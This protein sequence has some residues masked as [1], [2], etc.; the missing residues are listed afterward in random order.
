[1]I[2]KFLVII[3]IIFS[4]CSAYSQPNSAGIGFSQFHSAQIDS[5]MQVLFERGQFNGSILVSETDSII[6]QNGFGLADV[7][8]NIPFTVSTPC[9]LAS[10]TKQ[11]T[12]MAVMILADQKKLAY[13]DR[14][15]MYFPE[16]PAYADK[17]TIRR[18]LNHTSGIV[19]YVSLGLERPGLTNKDVLSALVKQDTLQFTPG[20]K[21]QYSNSGYI[22]LALIIEKVSGMPYSTFLKKNIFAPVDMK[23]TLVF[24]ESKPVIENKAI[25]Y[26]R[27]GDEDDYNLLTQG[28]G[29][30]YAT[31]ED[32]YKWD[33]ALYTEKLVK[34]ATLDEAF[35]PGKLNDGS[36]T[37]YGFG[38]G[39]GKSGDD[40][41]ASHAGRYGG[42]NTYIKRFSGSRSAIIFLTNCG[43]QNMSAIGNAIIAIMHNQPYILP[44][45]SVAEAMYKIYSSSGFDSAI[46]F[47]TNLKTVND[48]LYNWDES[49]LNELGYQL[50]GKD[51]TPD[52]IRILKLNAEAFPGSWN[53]YDGLGEAYMKHGD[54]ELAILNYKQS[55]KL[56]PENE[57]A[58][59][60]L[61]KLG[62]E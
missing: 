16:F 62:A 45:L 49:E 11:F 33:R 61:K 8:N 40:A 9:Y 50:L 17:I 13:S 58:E 51:K 56:N 37:G 1:M 34:R 36:I 54:K 23:N 15:S 26:S 60:M 19:D 22:L 59:A 20:D 29:G 52:A 5:L 14:L 7:K 25:G 10:L 28:E 21:F 44:K 48:P 24:D 32:L 39:I 27:F 53:V 46:S 4:L 47:Y 42:F 35:V 30:I 43:F 55:L 41:T 12:A 6:Y 31:V 57:N 38:W 2:S 3:S 18:L